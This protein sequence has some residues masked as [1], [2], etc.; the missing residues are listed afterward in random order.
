MVNSEGKDKNILK[1]VTFL[2]RRYSD[3][4]SGL[5]FCDGLNMTTAQPYGFGTPAV[6]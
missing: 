4:V 6:R 5:N 1:S 3:F 2:T